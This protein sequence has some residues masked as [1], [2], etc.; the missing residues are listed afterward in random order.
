MSYTR[1]DIWNAVVKHVEDLPLETLE[2]IVSGD[3][4]EYFK[5]AADEEE[6]RL[7]M[8]EGKV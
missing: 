8:E 1:E 7:F 3:L 2:E 5:S 6:L 4:Y